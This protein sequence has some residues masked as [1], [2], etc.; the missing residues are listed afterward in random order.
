MIWGPPYRAGLAAGGKAV[1]WVGRYLE[2]I[3]AW[4]NEQIATARRA[5]VEDATHRAEFG[6]VAR[7]VDVTSDGRVDP[8]C[9][10]YGLVPQ[11][12]S[13]KDVGLRVIGHRHSQPLQEGGTIATSN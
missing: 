8:G 13:T 7:V 2:R 12:P 6:E 11:I 10:P 4:T 1:D 5:Q 3:A 9:I